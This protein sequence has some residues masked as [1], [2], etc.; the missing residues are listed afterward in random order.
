MWE[1]IQDKLQEEGASLSEFSREAGISRQT[2]FNYRDGKS[3]GVSYRVAQRLT[4]YLA[5][6]WEGEVSGRLHR[7][8]YL[9]LDF[10]S[11]ARA[12][13]KQGIRPG[14]PGYESFDTH[15]EWVWA[16]PNELPPSAPDNCEGQR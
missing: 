5:P 10:L 16:H 7:R 13:R 6:G 1:L 9:T 3:S 12:L 4:E 8:G 2:L 11:M 15:L 14:T